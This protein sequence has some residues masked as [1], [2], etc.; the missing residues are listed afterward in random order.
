MLGPPGIAWTGQPLT[1]SRRQARALVYRLAVRLEVLSRERLCFL[2]WPDVPESMARRRLSRL[3]AHLRQALP[4]PNLLL[5][6]GDYVR[7]DPDRVWSDTA[8]F[9]QLCAQ[10]DNGSLE[11]LQKAIHLYRGPFL[12][13]FSMP[14]ALEVENWA[15]SEQRAFERLYLKYLAALMEA[16]AARGAYREAIPLAQ[17]YLDVDELAEGIHRRL[18]ELHA[19][20][21]DRSAAMQQYERCAAILE[22]ELSVDPAPE[23]QAAYELV[24]QDQPRPGPHARTIS[25]RTPTLPGGTPLVGRGEALQRLWQAHAGVQRGRGRVVLLFGEAGI[26]KSRLMGEF[27]AQLP[28]TGVLLTGGGY[29]STRTTPFLP[30]VEALRSHLRTR[31]LPLQVEPAWLG[32]ASLLLPE[33]RTE[34]PGLPQPVFTSVEEGRSRLFEALRQLLLGLASDGNPIVLCLDDL[35]TTDRA[36]LNWLAYLG[37][38][39]RDSRILVV[40]TYRTEEAGALRS[41]RHE[42]RQADVLEEVLLEPLTEEETLTL[43]RASMA[44]TPA[45]RALIRHLCSATGGNPFFLIETERL[46]LET[47]QFREGAGDGNRLPLPGSVHETINRRVARLSPKAQQSLAAGA[48]LGVI[49]DFHLVQRMTGQRDIEM[50]EGMDELVRSNLLVEGKEGYRFRH[51]M[52]QAVVYQDLGLSRRQV[53]HRRAAQALE[54][55]LSGQDVPGD[56]VERVRLLAQVGRHYTE[57]GMAEEAIEFLLQAG[58]QIRLLHG[59]EEAIAHYRRALEFLRASKDHDRT[60]RTLM[61][62]GLSY[63]NTFDFQRAQQTYDEAFAEWQRAGRLTPVPTISANQPETTLRLVWYHSESVDPIKVV[64]KWS[65]TVSAALFRGLVELTPE[66]DVVPDLAASWDVRDGGSTYVFHLR[67]DVCWSDGQPVTAHD[68]EYAWKRLLSPAVM[69]PLASELYVVR[70]ARAYHQ[71]DAPDADRVG[72]EARD[73]HTLVV[74]LEQPTGYFPYLLTLEEASAV[75][76][77]VVE[78]HPRS[79][80]EPGRIVFN[81]AFR[82]E[83]WHRGKVRSLL[84]NAAYNGPYSG[85]VQRVEL[86]EAADG[87]ALLEMYE[88]DGVDILNLYDLPSLQLADRARQTHAGEYLFLPRLRTFYLRFNNTECA[89]FD[90]PQV[91]RAFALAI[92]KEKLAFVSLGGYVLPATGGLVP[93]GMPGHSAGIGLP[94]EPEEARRLLAQAGYPGGHGFPPVLALGASSGWKGVLREGLRTQWQQALGIDIPW[95]PVEWRHLARKAEA[96]PYDLIFDGWEADFPDPDTFLRLEKYAAFRWKNETYDR[97]LAQAR[98][99]L[100]PR[101]RLALYRHAE[102]ILVEEVAF[103]PLA[104]GAGHK[105]VKPWV[106]RFPVSPMS[107]WFWKDIVLEAH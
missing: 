5:V 89:P 6:E 40:G 66:L 3:L 11:C 62:L 59:H 38:H 84:R 32:E 81:G 91:R 104:Y 85:N 15:L 92:D 17:R 86:H 44:E 26:G 48:V 72:V 24:L 55:Q 10:Q 47:G 71:G 21:G 87:T 13:G 16:H 50:A 61:K 22:R 79:W 69:A 98:W 23:T 94:Y 29:A 2:F 75:P 102:R 37:R 49:F 101:E 58:D 42:L 90:D 1:I 25:A 51:E 46:L 41:L 100:N 99:A 63:H 74:T 103:V 82:P 95:E 39:L 70:G 96:R 107:R 54:G 34:V 27:G 33:L 43:V 31:Q 4:A 76:R 77:H 97:L 9:E 80:T 14:A 30:L 7:F 73:G 106:K 65:A 78:A 88:A 93:P 28:S 18:I 36:T 52:I 35:H 56:E 57:A 105:L 45:N 68:F 67:D 83:T 12:A 8:A 60:A 53:L 64:E 19:A 20:A